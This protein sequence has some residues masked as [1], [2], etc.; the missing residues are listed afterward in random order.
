MVERN[1]IAH[2]AV[3]EDGSR[4]EGIGMRLIDADKLIERIKENND[5]PWNLSKVDQ[6]AFISCLKHAETSYDIEKVGKQLEEKIMGD[7][8]IRFVDQAVGKALEIV[9]QGGVGTDD[10]CEWIK[11]DYR[12]LSSPH[13]RYW[14]IPNNDKRLKYCP[15]CGKRIKVMEE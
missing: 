8:T 6:A 10:V 1:F 14:A 9:K 5:L 12:T 3:T 11:Y 7:E 13:E 4:K 2:G 15:Y